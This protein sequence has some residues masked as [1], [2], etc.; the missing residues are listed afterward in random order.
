MHLHHLEFAATG[1]FS[2][3]FLDYLNQKAELSPFYG[4]FLEIKNFE[5]VIH[6][7]KFNAES[8]KT[9]VEA[10]HRQY[11]GIEQSKQVSGNIDALLSAA[12]FTITTGH[13]FESLYRASVFCI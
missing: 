5:K 11:H 13:Q 10:L 4:E 12:T 7:R 2:P 1:R 8:R 6:E 3:L 9:L